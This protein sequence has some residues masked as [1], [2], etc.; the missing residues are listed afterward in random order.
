[1]IVSSSKIR[2]EKID[3]SYEE[4]DTKNIII[5]TGSTPIEIPSASFSENIVNS[6]GALS[7][8]TVPKTLGIVGAGI[9]GLELGS[10]WSRLG[11]DVT[12]LEAMNDFLPMTDPDIS[13]DAFKEFNNQGLNIQL[14][15][16]VTGTKDL[17]NSVKVKYDLK[18]KEAVSYTH[19][20]LPTKRIV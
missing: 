13:K 2:V 3:G 7:F 6:T 14:G 12:V 16:K 15:A 18:D 4:I 9:I 20:T 19:L 10:V 11:S 17:K 8:E 1:M 5:A